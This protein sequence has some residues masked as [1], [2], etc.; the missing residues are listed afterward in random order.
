MKS[1]IIILLFIPIPVFATVLKLGS[2]KQVVYLHGS[3]EDI[4]MKIVD[5]PFASSLADPEWRF[6]A[7]SKPFIPPSDGSWRDPSDVNLA[8]LYGIVVSGYL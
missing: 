2:V 7:V 8:S 3:D 4:T 6:S 1:L 5:V